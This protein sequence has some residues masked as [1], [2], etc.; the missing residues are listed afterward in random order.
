MTGNVLRIPRSRSLVAALWAVSF[1]LATP[2]EFVLRGLSAQEKAGA[3]ATD[4]AKGNGAGAGRVREVLRLPAANGA[5]AAP[6]R[7]EQEPKNNANAKWKPWKELFSRAT[8]AK[9]LGAFLLS[10][11]LAAAIAYHPSSLGKARRLSELEAPKTYVLYAVVGSLVGMLVATNDLL[12]LAI[13]GLG[14]LMRFRTDVGAAK[15]TGR[16]IFVTLIGLCCGLD[17]PAVAVYSTLFVF[18]LIFLLE[19]GVVYRI[20]VKGVGEQQIV[21]SESAYVE[22]LVEYGC[23]ILNVKKNVIKNQIQITF[24]APRTLDQEDLEEVLAEE[25]ADERKGVIDWQTR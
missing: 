20:A 10:A 19:R 25:I 4:E 24:R 17:K 1:C 7:R 22:L 16:V 8:A 11:L 6:D 9:L 5:A 21:S 15:D 13:F 3:A 12:G 14:G 23:R 18:V 2:G